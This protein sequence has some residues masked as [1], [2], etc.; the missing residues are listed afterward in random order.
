MLFEVNLPSLSPTMEE[1]KI[2]KWIK[3]EKEQVLSGEVLFEVETDK[4][5]MEYE[6]PE[7]GYI[8]KILI[9]EGASANVN[10][11]VAIISDDLDFTEK[12]LNSFS[13]KEMTS[14]DVQ[15]SNL[16]DHLSRY[17]LADLFLD[18]FPFGAHT[19]CVDALWS[20]L[21]VLTRRGNSFSSKVLSSSMF[22]PLT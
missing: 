21:P 16:E 2:V 19:T 8:A 5:T 9:S 13:K 17:K 6:S 18:T 11:L 10:Q 12:D 3:K 15:T 20:G 22:N 7:D 4:A 14:N 1:G